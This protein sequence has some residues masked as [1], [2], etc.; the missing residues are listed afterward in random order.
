VCG[1]GGAGSLHVALDLPAEAWE[2]PPEVDVYDVDGAWVAGVTDPE[3]TLDVPG[4]MYTVVARR[5]TV[6]GDVVGTAFGLL[7]HTATQVCVVDGE[8]SEWSGTWELQP[9]SGKLWMTSGED[10]GG[11]D[12]TAL[13][14]GGS[15][16]PVVGFHVDRSNDLRGFGVDPLGNLWVATSPTYGAKLLVFPASAADGGAEPLELGAELF[17]DNVQIQDILF[18]EKDQLW[19]LVAGSNA[20]VVGLWSFS[21]EQAF[22]FL[23]SGVMPDRP[24]QDI[25]VTGLVRAEDMAWGPDDR[26][27]LADFDG[28]QVLSV[29]V[30][31]VGG[32][33]PTEVAPDRVITVSWDDETGTHTLNGPTALDFDATG[34]L[35]VNYWTSATLARFDSVDAS[36]VRVPNLMAGDRE[37]DLLSA[38]AP[39]RAGNV[40][41]GNDTGGSGEI[42]SIEGETGAE[43]SRAGVGDLP[44]IDLLFDPVR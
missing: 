32:A 29:G 27:W 17:A 33:E 22:G 38:L 42:V 31:A 5:G 18:D 21:P 36:G 20:G 24:A 39:D 1:E 11:F 34:R 7:D 16:E 6:A 26:L 10:A 28:D 12:P 14:A 43:R 4:G 35:W 23:A 44:A 41:Y 37:L 3:A 25:T 2:K 40:W 9:S 30:G 13:A 15:A 8:T 19:V